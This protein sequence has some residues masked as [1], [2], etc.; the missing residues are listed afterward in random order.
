M[1][2]VCHVNNASQIRKLILQLLHVSDVF[3]CLVSYAEESIIL[4]DQQAEEM[5]AQLWPRK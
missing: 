3:S 5:I 4:I 2:A 1:T